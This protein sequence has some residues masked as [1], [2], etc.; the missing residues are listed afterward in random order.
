MDRDDGKPRVARLLQAFDE[1][2]AVAR[3][4]QDVGVEVLAFDALGV[5]QDDLSDAQRGELGPQAA[6]HFR[7]GKGEQ[8]IDSRTRRDVGL[9]GAAQGHPA[10]AGGFHGADAERA[11]DQPD[12]DSPARARRAARCS[13]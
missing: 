12:A 1:E 10:I 4:G 5:R 6:H 9:E 11:I 2:R 8:D 7:T 3:L 13:R